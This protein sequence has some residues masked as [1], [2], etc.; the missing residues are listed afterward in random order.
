MTQTAANDGSHKNFCLLWIRTDPDIVAVVQNR[1]A[2]ATS[3]QVLISSSNWCFTIKK[4][5]I[6]LDVLCL[7][8][9]Q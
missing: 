9:E 5:K 2:R 3:N 1:V 6:V 8:F 7:V 4:A